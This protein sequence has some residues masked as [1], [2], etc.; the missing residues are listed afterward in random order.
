MRCIAIEMDTDDE[1]TVRKSVFED[2]CV[3]C[4]EKSIPV[5]NRRKIDTDLGK[6]VKATWEMLIDD[7]LACFKRCLFL[8][9]LTLLPFFARA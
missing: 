9:I 6:R 1:Q 3:G 4:G 8:P 2:T 5:K 7:K